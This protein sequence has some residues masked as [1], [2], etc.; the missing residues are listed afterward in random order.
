GR[1]ADPRPVPAGEAPPRLGAGRQGPLRVASALALFGGAPVVD[2]A[3]HRRW[4]IIDESDRRAVLGVLDRGVLSGMYAPESAALEREFAA[5]TGAANAQ[6]THSGTSALE[7][8]LAA[9]QL[10]EGSE[11]IVPAYSFVA[12]P[13][14]VLKVG[15]IPVFSDVDPEHGNIDPAG[16]EALIT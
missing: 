1:R 16:I 4:P 7:V 13:M 3:A 10:G 14:A 5:F 11:V 6:L 9:L 2:R 12:T 15:M 8:A